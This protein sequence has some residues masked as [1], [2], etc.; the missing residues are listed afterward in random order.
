M[1]FYR[2]YKACDL[3]QTKHAILRK[4]LLSKESVS[5]LVG[6]NMILSISQCKRRWFI[7]NES[8]L[9]LS[10]VT[11]ILYTYLTTYIKDMYKEMG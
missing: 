11:F 9:K 3:S 4:K 8:I 1:R 6:H 10:K 5:A 2:G 7:I